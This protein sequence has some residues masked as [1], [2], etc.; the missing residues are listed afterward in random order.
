MSDKAVTQEGNRAPFP[1][2]N[3]KPSI[4][5]EQGRNSSSDNF[6]NYVLWSILGTAAAG[7]LLYFGYR[8]VKG[9]I[10]DIANKGSLD[11]ND[12]SYYAK[13]IRMGIDNNNSPG[14]D[15][16]TIRQAFVAIPSKDFFRKVESSYQ[17]QYSTNLYKD[18]EEH[19]K[20]T[21]FQEMSAI[22]RIKPEREGKNAQVIY[23]PYAWAQRINNAVNYETWGFMW[24]TDLDAIKQVVREIPS[25][26]AWSDVKDAYE[27]KYS[28][29]MEDDLDEDVSQGDYDFRAEIS[30]K[31]TS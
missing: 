11:N 22:Y 27:Q 20:T 15:T 23:D 24:G 17:K 13:Q 1:E 21:E 31:P 12:P 18:L 3:D 2:T 30:K 25:Q 8:F 16:N 7:T 4:I 29:S 6:K 19:L 10:S 14:T 26:K 5:V 9:K 28:V